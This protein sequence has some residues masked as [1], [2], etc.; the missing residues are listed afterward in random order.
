[1]NINETDWWMHT[2]MEELN[3]L[4]GVIRSETHTQLESFGAWRH[5]GGVGSKGTL[6]HVGFYAHVRKGSLKSGESCRIDYICMYCLYFYFFSFGKIW[7][8]QDYLRCLE[9]ENLLIS[10][11]NQT[12]EL[13][14]FSSQKGLTGTSLD[15]FM[16]RC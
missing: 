14:I 4:W 15:F 11:T 2:Y 8:E 7:V 9:R 10:K 1:M 16:S 3:L 13:N 12:W 6:H 5:K